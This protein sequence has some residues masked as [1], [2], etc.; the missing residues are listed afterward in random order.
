MCK[1][2]G[3]G[4]ASIGLGVILGEENTGVLKEDGCLSYRRE[5]LDE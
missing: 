3:I 5:E 1:I 4:S 2:G